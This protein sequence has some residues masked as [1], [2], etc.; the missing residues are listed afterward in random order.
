MNY[1]IIFYHSGKTAE[2][3]KI[4]ADALEGLGLKQGGGYAAADPEELAAILS[5]V[6]KKRRL[7]FIIGGLDGGCQSTDEILEKVLVPKEESALRDVVLGGEGRLICCSK[8]TL[9]MLP[10][11]ATEVRGILQKLKEQLAGIYELEEE[12]RPVAEIENVAEELD[13][14]LSSSRRERVTPTGMTAEKRNR[15]QLAALKATIAV[16][17]VLAA[18]QLAAASYLFITQM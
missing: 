15:S 3:E 4:L 2:L 5:G 16:L 10:D 17:L 14:E 8:Q 12:E 9:V 7:I 1:E 11:S 18:A 6:L 13:K